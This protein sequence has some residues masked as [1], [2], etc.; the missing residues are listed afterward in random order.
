MAELI[1]VAPSK[2]V[3]RPGTVANEFPNHN[4]MGNREEVEREGG[5][6]SKTFIELDKKIRKVRKKRE[7]LQKESRKEAT[8]RYNILMGGKTMAKRGDKKSHESYGTTITI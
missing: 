6:D 5:T 2:S 8:K 1:N 4:P 7:R 3:K